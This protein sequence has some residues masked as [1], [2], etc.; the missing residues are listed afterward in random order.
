MK[1]IC[2]YQCLKLIDSPFLLPWYFNL[3]IYS[4]R[5]VQ[6][7]GPTSLIDIIN[8]S[9]LTLCSAIKQ[10]N[11]RVTRTLQHWPTKADFDWNYQLKSFLGELGIR[12]HINLEGQQTHLK[13]GLEIPVFVPMTYLPTCLHL[14]VSINLRINTNLF[15]DFNISKLTLGAVINLDD[16]RAARTSQHW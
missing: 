14:K 2:S 9:N 8:T 15:E 12:I 11:I 1:N 13:A 16:L 7:C 4:S 3:N 5:W 10:D 6:T